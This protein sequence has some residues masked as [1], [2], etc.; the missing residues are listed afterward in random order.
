MTLCPYCGDVRIWYG[1]PAVIQPDR[2]AVITCLFC[3]IIWDD[4]NGAEDVWIKTSGQFNPEEIWK[5]VPKGVLLIQQ[6]EALE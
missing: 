2:E 4:T 5:Q 3:G 1:K 6:E